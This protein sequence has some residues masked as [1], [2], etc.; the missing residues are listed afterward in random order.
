MFAA[1]R[2]HLTERISNPS[3]FS[4]WSWGFRVSL[5][6]LRSGFFPTIFLNPGIFTFPGQVAVS[7]SPTTGSSF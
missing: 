6:V 1:L 7:Q 4:S 5:F 3:L 2:M